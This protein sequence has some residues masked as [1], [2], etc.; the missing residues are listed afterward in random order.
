MENA[1]IYDNFDELSISSCQKIVEKFLSI[2]DV[3]ECQ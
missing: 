1:E 3:E 2:L